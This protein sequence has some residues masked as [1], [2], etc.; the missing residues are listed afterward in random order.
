M[1]TAFISLF[2]ALPVLA[3]ETYLGT[4]A[5]TS[6]PTAKNN[7]GTATPFRIP[8]MAKV[9]VQC[10]ATAYVAT[11]TITATSTNGVKVVADV[12]F[13]TSVGIRQDAPSPDA[14]VSAITNSAVISV[15]GA[16]GAVNCKVFERR[17]NE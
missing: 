7:H 17:G 15:I 10:D 8:Q 6:G 13:P 1:K 5:A 2:L 12:A 3:G 16:S 4:I 14:G 11:D 9:T